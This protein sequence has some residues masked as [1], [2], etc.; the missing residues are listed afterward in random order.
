MANENSLHCVNLEIEAPDDHEISVGFDLKPTE[1]SDDSRYFEYYVQFLKDGNVVRITQPNVERVDSGDEFFS[2]WISENFL[3]EN[4]PDSFQVFYRPFQPGKS[5]EIQLEH[6]PELNKKSGSFNL[7]TPKKGMLGGGAWKTKTVEVESIVLRLQGQELI[8]ILN[9]SSNKPYDTLLEVNGSNGQEKTINYP[10][11][12]EAPFSTLGPESID[13]GDTLN[14][15]V[16]DFV[17]EKWVNS[18]PIMSLDANV[19]NVVSSAPEELEAQTEP[20]SSEKRTI[21]FTIS[22]GGGEFQFHRLDESEAETLR[23][24]VSDGEVYELTGWSWNNSI[25]DGVYG[26]HV[27]D[28]QIVNEATDSEVDIDEVT[29]EKF[30]TISDYEEFE[31]PKCLDVFYFSTCKISGQFSIELEEGEEFTPSEL[32]I[33]YIEYELGGYPERYGKPVSRIEY[34]GQDV[35]VEFEDSGSETEYLFIGYEFDGDDFV[36]HIVV[37]ENLFTSDNDPSS[38]DWSLLANIFGDEKKAEVKAENTAEGK[39]KTSSPPEDD[40]FKHNVMLVS[41]GKSLS[42]KDKIYDAARWEWKASLDRAKS[43]EYVIAHSSG[44]IVGVF[45]PTEWLPSDNQA[46]SE[47]GNA[48]KG[49]IGFIG[50]V[51]EPEVLVAYLNKDIPKSYFPRGAANPVRFIEK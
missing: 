29:L 40:F 35:F 30:E 24:M 18:M 37:F 50:D 23:E 48:S 14:L 6:P 33:I 2:V 17:A 10:Q 19:P 49:R 43:C 51:A 45:K 15:T 20:N 16:T 8:Y 11:I 5:I 38:A 25:C 39:E 26:V 46:F 28:M 1:A 31:K 7:C 13:V 9:L 41:I 44:K 12:I 32:K 3:E 42:E 4:K 22:G 27:N 47:L 36:D 21:E 34:K